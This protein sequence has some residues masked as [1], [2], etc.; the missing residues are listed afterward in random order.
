MKKKYYYI[1]CKKYFWFDILLK[2]KKKQKK[3][4]MPILA[5]VVPY[6]RPFKNIVPNTPTFYTGILF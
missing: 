1:K 3:S 6:D 4:Y 2:K 5:F